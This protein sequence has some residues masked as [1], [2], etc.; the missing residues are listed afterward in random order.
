LQ[1]GRRRSQTRAEPS[2]LEL[3]R[4]QPKLL[5]FSLSMKNAEN[6]DAKELIEVPL[7]TFLFQSF[8]IL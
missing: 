8:K 1:G 6:L 2:L 5:K 7:N 3:C 4:V